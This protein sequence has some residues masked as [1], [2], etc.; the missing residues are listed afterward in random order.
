MPLVTLTQ[1]FDSIASDGGALAGVVVLGWEDACAY[2]RAAEKVGCP[3]ILQAGPGCRAHT[4]LSVLSEMF[5]VLAEGAKV[6]VVAHLDHGKTPQDCLDAIDAGFTSVMYDGSALP[7]AENI[8]NTRQVLTAARA[9]GVSVEAELGIVGYVGAKESVGTSPDEARIFI[10]QAPVDALAISA[11]NTH[12]SQTDTVPADMAV[13]RAIEAAVPT[14]LVL[15]GGSGIPAAQRREI[16]LHTRVAKF[17]IGTELRLAFG[18]TLRERL[19][20]DPDVFDRIEILKSLIDPI[21]E[22][23][24]PVLANLLPEGSAA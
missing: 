16:A 14:P 20:S 11:G 23:T 5:R 7:L 12:L 6:P 18:H 15:H 10:E 2:V 3:V 22:R 19:A 4:P 24:A 13:I 9:A 17:N 21:A 1:A 8:E